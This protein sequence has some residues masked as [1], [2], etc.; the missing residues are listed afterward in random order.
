MQGRT[1]FVLIRTHSFSPDNAMDKLALQRAKAPLSW[2]QDR[3]PERAVTWP[4]FFSG[5][6]LWPQELHGGASGEEPGSCPLGKKRVGRRYNE[7]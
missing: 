5:L 4:H 6:K 7:E 2:R 3:F 1:T